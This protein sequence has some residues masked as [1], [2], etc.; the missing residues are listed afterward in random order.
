MFHSS[1]D[2]RSNKISDYVK[3]L[4]LDT[5]IVLESGLKFDDC[6]I[7][8]ETYGQLNAEKNNAGKK[9]MGG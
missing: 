9:E 3:H 5:Q 1:D 6:V 2:L 4:R 8:Y 7:A